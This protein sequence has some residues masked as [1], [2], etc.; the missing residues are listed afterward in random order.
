MQG[1]Q[2][3]GHHQGVCRETKGVCEAWHEVGGF[4][5][6][7]YDSIARRRNSVIIRH[8]LAFLPCTTWLTAG[9]RSAVV[10][11]SRR[12][13]RAFY[14]KCSFYTA[15]GGAARHVFVSSH[16]FWREEGVQPSN[17]L[18]SH[19]SISYNPLLSAAPHISNSCMCA[20]PVSVQP[21][22]RVCQSSRRY[23]IIIHP[24]IVHISASQ[25][26]FPCAL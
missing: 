5:N 8:Y 2:L 14:T 19:P 13:C 16:G 21:E 20:R 6:I 15:P 17:H 12:V 7:F 25:T 23:A 24:P 3:L 11:S 10:H 22:R 1:S 4:W 9:M 26:H 18:I